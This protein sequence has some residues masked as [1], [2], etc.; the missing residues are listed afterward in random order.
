MYRM[1]I[2]RWMLLVL[3]ITGAAVAGLSC[4]FESPGEQSKY[5]MRTWSGEESVDLSERLFSQPPNIILISID[6]LRGDYFS[7]Q[8]MP[9]TYRFAK[10]HCLIFS[11]AH[12][13][14]TWTKPSH[15]TMF[16]GMLQSTHGVE[17]I[18]SKIPDDI[19]MVQERLQEAGY[20][21]AAFVGGGFVGKQWGF[22]RGFELFDQTPSNRDAENPSLTD[23]FER[24][25]LPLKK[26]RDFLHEPD[27]PSRPFFLFV[28]TYEVHEWW[29]HYYPPES[30]Q[31]TSKVRQYASKRFDLFTNDEQKR[32][33]YGQAVRDLDGRLAEFLK[34]AISLPFKDNLCIILTSDHGEGLGEKHG[35]FLKLKHSGP[36]YAEQI[37]I[38]LAVYGMRKGTTNRLVGLDEIAP[39]ILWAAEISQDPLPNER[40]V[41]VSEYISAKRLDSN[42]SVA[43]LTPDGKYLLSSDGSFH[44]Y[45]D[46]ED[47]IDLLRSGQIGKETVQI[48]EETKKEL[49]AL[50]YMN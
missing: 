41:L 34:A 7:P 17:Y 38:P 32:A 50:G 35:D 6:T 5:R 44:L 19:G 40:R 10:K 39:L 48:T 43:V 4:S 11:N 42:R 18:D 12:S 22:D 13:N 9:Q 28:Q 31:P 14:S 36:P 1:R 24:L 29:C 21:T 26:A 8:H 2:F 33:I 30:E 20:Y 45:K 15:L 37:R 49:K 16:T 27:S 25:R 23:L 47:A 3:S 46:P